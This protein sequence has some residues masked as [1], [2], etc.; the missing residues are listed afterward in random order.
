MVLFI[1]GLLLGV[2]MSLF[3][4][5]LIAASD[6]DQQRAEEKRIKMTSSVPDKCKKCVYRSFADK[7]FDCAVCHEFAE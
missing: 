3:V 5:G 2:V 1:V 4:L 7:P 6:E